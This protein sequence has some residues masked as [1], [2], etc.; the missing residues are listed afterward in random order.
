MTTA[1]AT[2]TAAETT[3]RTGA[4]EAKPNQ[5]KPSRTKRR[6]DIEGLRGLAIAMV[7]GFH[8]WG[9]GR[10]SGG[11][12]VFLL[13]SAYLMTQSF[14]RKQDDF[15]LS[16]YLVRRFRQLLPSA[17][18]VI[19]AT[20]IGAAIV[21]PPVRWGQAWDHALA[22][23]FYSLNWTLID[24][25]VTYG[26]DSSASLFQHFWSMSIQG[27][28]FVIWPLLMVLGL[29]LRRWFG[30]ALRPYLIA[31]FGAIT[32]VSFVYA[33]QQ[34]LLVPG[35][36]YFDTM[37]RAW[38][39]ALPSVIAVI[40]IPRLPAIAATLLGWAGLLAVIS[41]PLL[42]GHEAFPGP[43][44]LMPVLGATA[45]LLAHDTGR[46]SAAALLSQ[47][48]FTWLGSRAY[49]F[50]LWHWPI[51]M[52]YLRVT[53]QPE[54][55]IVGGIS[56]I[57]LALALTELTTWLV[58]ERFQQIDMVQ[59]KRGGVAVIAVAVLLGVGTVQGWTTML[60]LQVRIGD[61]SPGAGAVTPGAPDPPTAAPSRGAPAPGDVRVRDDGPTEYPAC[62][63]SQVPVLPDGEQCEEVVPDGTPTKVV[64]MVGDSH[65][66]D[67]MTVLG[68][69]AEARG[70]HLIMVW[71]PFCRYTTRDYPDPIGE[72]CLQYGEKV[73][74]WLLELKP[75][76]VFTI[77]TQGHPDLPDRLT[78]GLID[79][80]R[81]VH[82]AG[83]TIVT[84]RD[85]PRFWW[86][87]PECVQ[88]N[89]L[90]SPQCVRPREEKLALI[91]PQVQIP[92]ELPGSYTMDMSNYLCPLDLCPAVLGNVYVYR[93]ANHLARAYVLTLT[94]E[95]IRQWDAQVPA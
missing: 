70:W 38:E 61:P 34:T 48:P 54:A 75:D 18:I 83:T 20:L 28:I 1:S 73:S 78:P 3:P 65:T 79:A 45:I 90:D 12:D 77:G 93:D 76:I 6:R 94:D 25:T 44:A 16:N 31:V 95:F 33:W 59:T 29:L 21:L 47:R 53:E 30:V 64:T 56:V 13:L 88:L 85:N 74:A 43:A 51:L 7:A 39:F 80:L 32:V 62:D 63:R 89:G 50:Y 4:S 86:E 52:L 27:Q 26:A 60:D 87:M 22:A 91:D 67:W 10:I 5:A 66:R 71:K 55:G 11:V 15:S 24:Q 41:T 36:A 92:Y 42:V 14:F 19:I 46:F 17:V 9:Q 68:P 37:A 84:M 72:D 69:M 2:G 23:L 35:R 82:E 81:P 49:G 40:A 58:E 8:I 57:L